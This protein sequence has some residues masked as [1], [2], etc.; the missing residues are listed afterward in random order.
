MRRVPTL[1]AML[2]FLPGASA[3]P[4]LRIDQ[5]QLIGSH[6]SYRPYPSPHG[7]ARIEAA[8][9]REWPELAYGHPP[10]ETQLALGLRQIE[11]DV[12]PDPVGGAYAAPYAAADPDTRAAMAAPGAK[13]LHIAGL[14]TEVHCLTFRAC[15]AILRHWSDRN[16]QHTPVA[17]L[18]NS[19]D[20]GGQ[21]FDAAAL[22][23][24]DAEIIA[25]MGPDRLI[26]PDL[27]R[28][29]APTL[30]DAV[31]R[32]HRWPTL[33]QAAG[34]FM[35][36]LDGSEA[37]ESVYRTGHA[38]LA[39][40]MMFGFY[41][42]AAPEAAV[43]NIGNPIAQAARIRKL[44]DA[45]F[46]VRTRADEGGVEA[47]AND[48]RRLDMAVG[49]GAQWISTDFYEGVPDPAGLAYRVTLPGGGLSRC[50][51]RTARCAA[52]GK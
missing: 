16:P 19:G 43:F 36:V 32:A 40:R 6:N 49:S 14:D 38:S 31:T 37:H 46:I 39:G 28:G 22:D 24:L 21:H 27:V 25:A 26:T 47:R 15:L 7:R 30:R 41:D 50:N 51:P 13:V 29:K 48:R 33:H 18:V 3:A 44:V 8:A 34:R 35:F 20:A 23:A 12:A 11:I 9:P 52:K 1:L 4:D 17:V 2:A 5:L 42:E 45:G 10:L